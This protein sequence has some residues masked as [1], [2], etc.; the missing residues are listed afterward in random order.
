MHLCTKNSS[1]NAYE[2]LYFIPR[3]MDDPASKYNEAWLLFASI[4]YLCKTVNVLLLLF[5]LQT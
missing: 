4:T 5:Y 2:D 3:R 1:W